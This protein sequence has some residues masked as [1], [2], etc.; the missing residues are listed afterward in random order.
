MAGLGHSDKTVQ[1]I[2][3]Q[4]RHPRGTLQRLC[5]C[6]LT[7]NCVCVCVCV[8]VCER[9]DLFAVCK[10][11]I[12]IFLP[13]TTPHLH[14]MG[15]KHFA[16]F[17]PPS[18]FSAADHICECAALIHTY[19]DALQSLYTATLRWEWLGNLHKA[20]RR[21]IMSSTSGECFAAALIDESVLA[22]ER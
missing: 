3:P 16:A 7:L 10:R 21:V 8:C 17:F 15:N 19:Q 13:L 5:M 22:A 14:L 12:A 20:V 2:A 18:L 4:D 6:A 9:M 1:L 11:A